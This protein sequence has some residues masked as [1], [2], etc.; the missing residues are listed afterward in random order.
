MNSKTATLQ[1][2]NVSYGFDDLPVIKNFSLT[3][4]AGSFTTLLGPSGCGKTTLLRL[5]AGFLTP[6]TG[7]IFI[8]GKNQKDVSA[9]N[10]RVGMVFQDYALFP[11][12]SVEKNLFY[13][14]KN[15]E[16]HNAEEDR[17]K[18]KKIADVLRLTP[19]LKRYPHELSGGQ[20]QR[21]A[22]GRAIIIEPK[23]ILMDEPLSALDTKLRSYVR[24]ELKDLQK[25]LGITTLYVT[26]D[27]EEALSLSDKIAVIK[28]GVL[29]QI[30]TPREIYYHPANSFVAD[31]VGRANIFIHNNKRILVRPEW[32]SKLSAATIVKNKDNVLS[33]TVISASFF[34]QLTRYKISLN[35]SERTVLSV[36]LPSEE[37]NIVN[38][39]TINVSITRYLEL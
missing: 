26:H 15:L 27:Q 6:H 8:D 22:L 2:D 30:G 23:I 36:D 17:Q 14:L 3:V 13:G 32:F 1:F 16:N 12:L 25:S 19:F 24:D 7:S 18:V 29:Q 28:D 31:S 21:V 35:D 11:H 34:G 37:N 4:E 10:R 9:E 38:G 39:Q 33:G 5:V 20:Q